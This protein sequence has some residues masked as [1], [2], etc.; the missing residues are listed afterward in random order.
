MGI[1]FVHVE[2][3]DGVVQG[4]RNSI[5]NALELRLPCTNPYISQQ[6]HSIHY[7]TVYS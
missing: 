6:P 4:K 3:N 5:A 7:L 2:H 1:W